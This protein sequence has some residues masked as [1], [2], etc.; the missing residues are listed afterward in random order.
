MKTTTG[1]EPLYVKYAEAHFEFQDKKYTVNIYQNQGLTTEPEYE[2][3]LF[4][5]FTDLTNGE[6]TY[7]GGRFIDL[8]IPEG[9]EII[10]DFNTAYNP[11][12]AYNDRYSCPIPPEENH[13]N[14]LIPVGVKK[15]KNFTNNPLKKAS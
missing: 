2:D 13:L 12:C 11:Y 14:L 8:S 1:R 10:I 9:D 7:A 3:Y 5:P 6:T 4:L 15:Y